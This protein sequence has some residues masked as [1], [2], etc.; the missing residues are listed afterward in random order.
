MKFQAECLGLLPWQIH[1]T[2]ERSEVVTKQNPIIK[3]FYIRV[4]LVQLCWQNMSAVEH[5]SNT[6]SPSQDMQ[7]SEADQEKNLGLKVPTFC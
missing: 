7:H 5:E 6:S 1:S 3:H 2:R 4:G